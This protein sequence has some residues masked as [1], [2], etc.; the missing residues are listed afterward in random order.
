MLDIGKINAHLTREAPMRAPMH[1]YVCSVLLATHAPTYGFTP[2]QRHWRRLVGA[3]SDPYRPELH[4]MRGPG[5]RCGRKAAQKVKPSYT[6]AHARQ[7]SM[8]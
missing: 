7:A 8:D 5:P 4:Y 3:P 2:A 6:A 1:S